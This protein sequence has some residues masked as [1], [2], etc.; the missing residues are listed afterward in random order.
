MEIVVVD[1]GSTN[2]TPERLKKYKD[3]KYI[4]KKNG[5]KSQ[6]LTWASKVQ[7]AKSYAY[8]METT[9]SSRQS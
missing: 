2:D 4:R 3:I 1:D 5:C 8:S 9:S 7:K 6:L